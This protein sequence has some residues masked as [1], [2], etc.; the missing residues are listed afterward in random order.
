MNA[1]TRIACVTLSLVAACSESTGGAGGPGAGDA[2][3]PPPSGTDASAC[4]EADL[5]ACEY[6]Q[7]NVAAKEVEGTSVEDTTTKRVLPLLARVPEGA[8]PFP[9]VVWSHG[10]GFNDG[11]HRL[12]KEWG[13]TIAGQG[14]VV[15][16]VA[17]VGLTAEAAQA[18]CAAASIPPAECTLDG[19]SADDDTPLVGMV[20]TLD[21]LAVLDRLD[22][23][24]KGSVARGGPALDL[25]RVA[26]G[27]WSAGSRAPVVLLGAKLKVTP[28]APLFTRP[29]ERVVASVALSTTGPGFGGFY[30]DGGDSSWK[31]M[32]GP[33]FIGTGENDVKP[34]KPELTGVLRRVPFTAQ[35]GD[36]TRR[37]LY[38]NLPVGVG[39][40]ETYNL[41]HL[42][43][44][45]ERL[46]RFSRALR[47]A[48]LAF[49]DD[50]VRGDAA[51]KAWLSTDHAKV[52]AGD[53][54]WEHR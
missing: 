50:T 15:I 27:G 5:A 37:L 14:F 22:E 3:A 12:G 4:S 1:L 35:P 29:H 31:T 52:L 21:V 49:L 24:S 2:A 44:S 32:R 10:G 16:H 23:L 42:G 38:S 51:A 48:V 20:K 6:P 8:G 41:E 9:V 17:H 28:S 47:S 34:N 40:H 7:R 18:V 13:A 45:D 19:V 43:S 54:D 25:S 36:G 39:G 30:D 33:L 26:T 11:G 46:A 53:A